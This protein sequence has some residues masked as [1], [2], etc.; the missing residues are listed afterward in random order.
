MISKVE[1]CSTE[2]LS[3]SDKLEER[4]TNEV[5]E[6]DM[7]TSVDDDSTLVIERSAI[8]LVVSLSM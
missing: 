4:F 2:V 6:I 3:A 1:V 8:E 5:S 7:A